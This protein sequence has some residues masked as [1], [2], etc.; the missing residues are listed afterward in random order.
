M[1]TK[2][3]GHEK[4]RRRPCSRAVR[5]SCCAVKRLNA[6]RVKIHRSYTVEEVAHLF[7]VHKNTVRAWIRAGLQAVDD[8]RPTLILGRH[9]A[10]FLHERI[11]RTKRPCG[12]GQLYCVR[13]RAPRR[14][15]TTTIEY[16]PVTSGSGN[17]RGR[18]ADCGTLMFR[19]VSLQKLTA[20]AGDLEVSFLLAERRIEDSAHRSPNCDL[21]EVA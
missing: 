14:P 8:R 13:C 15:S 10:V 16:V 3:D 20:V 7:D 21:D 17:L 19:R 4:L 2:G 18:C 11:R 1:P 6:R 9:L 12:A 5:V